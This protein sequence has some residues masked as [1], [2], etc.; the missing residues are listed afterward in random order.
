[1]C[2]KDVESHILPLLEADEFRKLGIKNQEVTVYD[3]DCDEY[4]IHVTFAPSH[5]QASSVFI[6]KKKKGHDP[7]ALAP[8]PAQEGLDLPRPPRRRLDPPRPPR[9][10]LDPPRPSTPPLTPCY[11]C[12]PSQR[13]G[14]YFEHC[15]KPGTGLLCALDVRSDEFESNSPEY[16]FK[17]QV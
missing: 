13:L 4:P 12:P 7:P 8:G 16:F 1:M 6:W 11:P 14:R 9:R 17:N 2:K 5:Q 15:T 10:R 3:I